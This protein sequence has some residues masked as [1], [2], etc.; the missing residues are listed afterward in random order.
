MPAVLPE[1]TAEGTWE[2]ERG[3]QTAV[4]MPRKVQLLE[5]PVIHGFRNHSE[6]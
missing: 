5:E 3:N 2:Q 4:L 6:F 1:G